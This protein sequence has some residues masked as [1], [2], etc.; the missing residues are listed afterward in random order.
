MCERG[1]DVFHMAI[2]T[3]SDH[4]LP[5]SSVTWASKPLQKSRTWVR[6]YCSDEAIDDSA[7][8]W[9]TI[10]RLRPWNSLS[11]ELWVL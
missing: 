2:S 9:R 1:K 5:F 6:T 7:K 8:A 3:G 4:P 11:M 10:L